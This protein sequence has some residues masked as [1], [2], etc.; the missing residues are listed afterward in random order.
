MSQ[1]DVDRALKVLALYPDRAS[2]DGRVVVKDSQAQNLLAARIA[3]NREY[4]WEEHAELMRHNSTPRDAHTW[5]MTMPD[6]IALASLRRLRPEKAARQSQPH[7][8]LLDS[9]MVDGN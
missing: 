3:T 2:K 1:S 9:E 7:D 5:A 4:P 6:P 8:Y